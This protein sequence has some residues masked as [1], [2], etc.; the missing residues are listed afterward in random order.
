MKTLDAPEREFC[1]LKRSLTNTPL[2]SLLLLNGI[3]FVEAAR[4]M[5]TA[6]LHQP[7]ELTLSV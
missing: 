4:H 7:F 3:Q 5:A 1:T 6:V 2:Q